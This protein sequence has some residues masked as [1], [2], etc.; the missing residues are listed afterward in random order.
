[1]Q[2]SQNTLHLGE[3][4]SSLP[5][6]DFDP[7]RHGYG[8]VRGESKFLTVVEWY[9]CTAE[10][11]VLMKE[12]IKRDFKAAEICFTALEEEIWQTRLRMATLTKVDR[13]NLEK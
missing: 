5:Y 4:A 9:G 6:C 12:A 7:V 10:E 2:E 8:L 11:V 13:G 3:V 1:M